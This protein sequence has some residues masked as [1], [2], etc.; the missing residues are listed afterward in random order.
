MTIDAD[1]LCCNDVTKWFKVAHSTGYFVMPDNPYGKDILGYNVESLQGA[2]SPPCHNMPLFCNVTQH[3]DLYE[4]IWEWGLKEPYG[5]MVTVFKT[6]HRMNRVDNILQLPNN[7]WIQTHYYQSDIRVLKI[8]NKV[9]LSSACSKINMVHRR[10][11][12]KSVC[13]KFVNDIKEPD[14]KKVGKH[15]VQ[16]FYNMY[17]RLNLEHKVVLDHYK[18]EDPNL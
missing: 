16:Q 11:W 3:K 17:K 12:M 4:Q 5:D 1:M 10:F 2:A 15:N 14:N 18:W 6:M 13:E 7:L 9:Y 8:D